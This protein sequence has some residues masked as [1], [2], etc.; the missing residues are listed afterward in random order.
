ML[1]WSAPHLKVGEEQNT[2]GGSD[3]SRRVVE[4]PTVKRG[5]LSLSLD[6]AVNC[7]QARQYFKQDTRKQDFL[8]G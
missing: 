4:P 3:V 7:H 1:L 2:Q 5:S 6:R 8:E